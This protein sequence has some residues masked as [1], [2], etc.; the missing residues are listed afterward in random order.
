MNAVGHCVLISYTL[1]MDVTPTCGPELKLGGYEPVILSWMGLQI[2]A[3]K[4]RR[5]FS[6]QPYGTVGSLS[7]VGIKHWNFWSAGSQQVFEG[8]YHRP[9]VAPG[10]LSQAAMSRS[11]FFFT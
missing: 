5:G 3:H 1:S 8:C 4:G 7:V 10:L 2:P 11:R 6:F 9:T